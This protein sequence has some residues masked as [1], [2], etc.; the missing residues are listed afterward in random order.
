MKLLITG[1][2]GYIGHPLAL[3]LAEQGHQVQILVRNLKSKNIPA[4][5]NIRLFEGDITDPQSIAPAIKGCKHV[6]HVAAYARLASKNPNL[7]YQINVKGTENML[8]ESVKAGVEKFIYTSSVAVF[9]PSLNFPLTENDPRIKKFDNDYELTKCMAENLVRNYHEKGL[10]GVIVNLSRVYGPGAGEYSNGVNKFISKVLKKRFL[11]VPDRQNISAN[12]VFIDDVIAG[13]LMAMNKG[14]TGESYIIG[15]ENVSYKTLFSTIKV[16][17]GTRS[18]F[19]KIPYNLVKTGF[20][21]RHFLSK[22]S[23][24]ET[25]ISP[26]ILEQLFTNRCVSSQKAITQLGY[27]YTPLQTGIQKTINYLNYQ[28]HEIS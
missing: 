21:M 13:H 12:Y 11:V 3:K 15:G 7:F 9:G 23:E 14:K 17:A 26:K 28:S 22:F 27:K 20:Y 4:H 24:T 1:A 2:T 6:F 10:P 5:P 8:I 25:L 16:L 18:K 19:I